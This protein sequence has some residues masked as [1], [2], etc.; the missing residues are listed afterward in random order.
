M[1]ARRP[2]AQG[3]SAMLDTIPELALLAATIGSGYL[4]LWRSRLRDSLPPP[5]GP[6]SYPIIGQ[7]LSV[8]QTSEAQ[9]FAD[10]GAKVNCGCAWLSFMDIDPTNLT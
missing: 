2:R 3:T 9:A 10:I 8:P 5:P 4:L 1:S 7:L 6:P